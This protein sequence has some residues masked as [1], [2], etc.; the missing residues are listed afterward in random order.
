VNNSTDSLR[1]KRKGAWTDGNIEGATFDIKANSI[2]YVG[3]G[4]SYKYSLEEDI[5]TIP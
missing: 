3:Q 2:F 5:I 4:A 1:G